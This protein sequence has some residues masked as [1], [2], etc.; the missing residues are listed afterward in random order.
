MICLSQ[1]EDRSNQAMLARNAR[2]TELLQQLVY[3]CRQ[4]QVPFSEAAYS[5]YMQYEGPPPGEEDVF[6]P[7]EAGPSGLVSS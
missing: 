1:F 7:S 4:H 5:D 2:Q 3:T 6:D